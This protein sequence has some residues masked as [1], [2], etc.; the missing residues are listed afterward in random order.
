MTC[1][2]HVSHASSRK[3]STTGVILILSKV[4]ETKF[5]VVSSIF[6]GLDSKA[7]T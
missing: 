2:P 7:F 1:T 6:G 5:M 3:I 4:G